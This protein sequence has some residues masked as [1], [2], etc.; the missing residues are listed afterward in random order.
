MKD[1]IRELGECLEQSGGEL[2]ATA[3]YLDLR[4]GKFNCKVGFAVT[5]D[6]TYSK[7]SIILDESLAADYNLTSSAIHS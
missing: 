4:A 3:D 1:I 5:T 6:P 7:P 2:K